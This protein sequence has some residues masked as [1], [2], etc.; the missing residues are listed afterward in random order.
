MAPKH[1][2]IYGKGGVGTSTTA[3]NISAALAESGHWVIQIGFDPK[4]DSTGTLRGEREVKTLLEVVQEKGEVTLENVAVSGFKEVLCI[5]SGL[6]ALG[7]GCTGRD[8]SAVMSFLNEPG[9]FEKYRPDFVIYDISAEAVCGGIAAPLLNSLAEQVYVV[10]SSDF[11]S[12]FAVN[13]LLRSFNNHGGKS[14]TVFGG[15]IGNGLTASFAE[16]VVADFAGRIGSPVAGYIPRSLVVTQSDLYGLTVIEA[17]P[18]SNLAA[19]YRR[20]A[21][22][23]AQQEGAAVPRPLAPEELRLWARGWGDRIVELETGIING[24]EG[25]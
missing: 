15:I 20:L 22:H 23:I 14:D 19:I 25:I 6:P 24:G 5:E 2:A 7:D 11:M 1:I 17:A 3:S 4:N 12:L 18:L 8:F 21:R 13:S 9:L 16:S 10:S